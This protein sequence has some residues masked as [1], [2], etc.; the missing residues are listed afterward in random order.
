MR[1]IHILNEE[2]VSKISAG[3]VVEKP[4]SAVKE[5]V[6]NS[7]DAGASS[8]DVDV[9]N[10]GVSLIRV[11][12]N[13]SGMTAEDAKIACL[14]HST[15]K[16]KSIEDLNSIY[17]LGFRGEALASITSVSQTDIITKS[18]LE[19]NGTYLYLESGQVL[20]ARPA[21]RSRGTTIE[22]RNLFYN[23][24]ARRKFLKKEASE[25]AEIMDVM[26][27]FVMAW[28]EIEFKLSNDGKCVL[29]ASRDMDLL[30]RISL[31]MG[32]DVADNMFRIE[33]KAEDRSLTGYVSL[34]SWTK[35]DRK[36]QVFFMNRRFV[37]SRTV[38]DALCGAYRSMLERG[39]YPSAVLSL[40]IPS[41]AVDVNV[42]P[43]KLLVRFD[44]EDDIRA[45]VDD[46]VRIGFE[47]IKQKTPVR[48]EFFVPT[49]APALDD[50]EAV[51]REFKYDLTREARPAKK[52][53]AP[54]AEELKKNS[55]G[56]VF[57]LADSYIVQV[58]PDGLK[59]MDQHA[60]H[61]RVLYE[62]FESALKNGNIEVQNL[63]FPVRLDLSASES[64]LMG[65]VALDLKRIGFTVEE[66]GDRSFVVQS[67]PAVIAD[68]DIKNVIMEVLS[69]LER[70]DLARVDV[71]D[72]LKKRTA[73]RAAIKAGDRLTLEEMLS[74]GD[75]L[76][77]CALP[78]TCPHGRPTMLDIS[79][80]ELEKRFHRK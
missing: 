78:F 45:L 79:L 44:K 53:F 66:F 25:L 27:H 31:V 42:H 77:A 41:E 36:N 69:D 18:D 35:K 56:S 23:V 33:H 50:A 76:N 52:P 3:E 8:V 75:Q 40:H 28:P 80:D 57:Q 73:C 11:A 48:A 26:G 37:R 46:A 49:A 62:F 9:Q 2:L 58:T 72:E 10:G 59:V 19:E 6:E 14:E 51:Q 60:A 29:K 65:K 71:V 64:V 4:A 74:L 55:D 15:S 5:L 38:S 34:P 63:L 24:P 39:K 54:V 7:I 22:V 67:V 61:E 12:D 32:R 70:C 47:A 16:I 30:E 43:A 13:G 68:K 1:T 17:T 21:A 20:R